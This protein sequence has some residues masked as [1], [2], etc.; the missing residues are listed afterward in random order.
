MSDS[1]D[2]THTLVTRVN[3]SLS[4]ADWL[5]LAFGYALWVDIEVDTS[6]TY[7]QAPDPIVTATR[8]TVEVVKGGG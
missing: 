7:A 3:V 4:W 8:S 2:D 6:V 5:S 1:P